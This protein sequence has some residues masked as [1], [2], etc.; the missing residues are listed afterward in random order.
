MSDRL[1]RLALLSGAAA[2][3]LWV[4]SLFLLEGAGNPSGPAGG[5]EIAEFYRDERTIILAAATLHVLGGFLFLWF[6]AA[7]RPVLDAAR[8]P[9]WLSTAILVGGAAGGAM[10]LAMTGGQST[11]ATTDSELLTAD[12]AI[13]SGGW[14]T[15][16]SSLPRSRS[17]SFLARSR[18][19]RSGGSCSR[20]GWGGSGSSSR[21]PR[22][23]A[24]R[25]GGAA[26]PA[27]SLADHRER[28]PLAWRAGG[29]ETPTAT[30]L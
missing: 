19:S 6:V 4:V 8:S 30:T 5:A 11:G 27:A 2:A 22:D 1:E 9:S 24:D 23:P 21:P 25:V 16:S 17:P 3:V 14:R 20:A 10:M 28:G 26:L 13:V 7:L 12:T 15:G 18:S 29:S